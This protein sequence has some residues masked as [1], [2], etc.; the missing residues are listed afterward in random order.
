MIS[1]E[2]IDKLMKIVI[3]EDIQGCLKAAYNL[4]CTELSNHVDG[5]YQLVV[6]RVLKGD[7][8]VQYIL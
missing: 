8:E 6:D 2:E 3:A 7:V 1:Q 5:K 4:V